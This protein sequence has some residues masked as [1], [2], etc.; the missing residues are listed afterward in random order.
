[1]YKTDKSTYYSTC[2]K[3]KLELLLVTL[4]NRNEEQGR[5][6]VT[7]CLSVVRDRLESGPQALRWGV[8]LDFSA[9]SEGQGALSPRLPGG[10]RVKPTPVVATKA[11]EL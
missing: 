5:I 4:Q 11:E 2:S 6:G 1:M 7:F 8:L 3:R 10:G 9:V